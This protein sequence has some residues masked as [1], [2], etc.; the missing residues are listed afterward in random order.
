M[1]GTLLCWNRAPSAATFFWHEAARGAR[2]VLVDELGEAC[3]IAISP[4][5]GVRMT[6]L[7]PRNLSFLRHANRPDVLADALS[8]LL[9]GARGLRVLATGEVDDSDLLAAAIG[10]FRPDI[11]DVAPQEWRDDFEELVGRRHGGTRRMGVDELVL[12]DVPPVSSDAPLPYAVIG[13]GRP[14]TLL[15]PGCGG[16]ATRLVLRLL[17]DRAPPDLASIGMMFDD[18]GLDARLDGPRIEAIAPDAADAACHVLRIGHDTP[19]RELAVTD[20]EIG[21]AP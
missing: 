17:R 13:S 9:G 2:I 21:P 6:S 11:V 10:S 1:I 5:A 8:R 18:R 12:F 3:R 20:I 16:G 15:L 14:A 19:G 7:P 4:P